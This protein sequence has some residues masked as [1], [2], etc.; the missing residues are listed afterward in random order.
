MNF[1]M[2]TEKTS[3]G[4]YSDYLQKTFDGERASTCEYSSFEFSYIILTIQTKRIVLV[5]VY[6]KQKVIFSTFHDEFLGTI[7]KLW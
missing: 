5:C 2:R 6:R 4:R 3:E 1:T 7:A